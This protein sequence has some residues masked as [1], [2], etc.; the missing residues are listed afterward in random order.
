M[1]PLAHVE[2]S[3]AGINIG[4]FVTGEAEASV[5]VE[6]EAITA[7][8]GA[9]REQALN[10]RQG[11]R[12]RPRHQG[13][14]VGGEVD[15]QVRRDG[16]A[17]TCAVKRATRAG[18]LRTRAGQRARAVIIGGE[19]AGQLPGGGRLIVPV[20]ALQVVEG[21]GAGV[22]RSEPPVA[23]GLQVCHHG[24]GAQG[25][26]RQDIQDA[27]AIG[28]YA[29]RVA[30]DNTVAGAGVCELDVR[31]GQT[32]V[33]LPE[34]RDAVRAPLVADRRGAGDLHGNPGVA[35]GVH[36]KAGR[37]T[38]A[39]RRRGVGINHVQFHQI[40]I[41]V[42]RATQPGVGASRDIDGCVPRVGGDGRRGHV[43]DPVLIQGRHE[44]R[45]NSRRAVRVSDGEDVSGP[46][47]NHAAPDLGRHG[48]IEE[49]QNHAGHLRAIGSHPGAQGVEAPTGVN[50][51]SRQNVRQAHGLR[52]RELQIHCQES[53]P[54]RRRA[55]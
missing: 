45:R 37:N 52:K 55:E 40:N 9:V 36:R 33:G 23:Q 42:R 38:E 53:C 31:D 51:R 49:I 39:Q 48:I 29:N 14:S 30:E 47:E 12:L 19:G 5:S 17:R 4:H 8:A 44:V 11:G 22:Q 35:A 32:G 50:R 41:S 34:E 10:P 3:D 27:V 15:R 26:R 6:A 46:I 25:G 24:G 21:E 43:F 54:I 16:D 7:E 18:V 20:V 1:V 13:E 2:R 28:R